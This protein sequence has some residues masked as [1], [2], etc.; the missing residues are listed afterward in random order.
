MLGP[1][2]LRSTSSQERTTLVRASMDPAARKDLE[3]SGPKFE[4]SSIFDQACGS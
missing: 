1:G 3:F 2:S 4:F